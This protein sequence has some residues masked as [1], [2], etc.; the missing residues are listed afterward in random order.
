MSENMRSRN[1]A[2]NSYVGMLV[3]ALVGGL[4]T[5]FIVHVAYETPF[6]AFASP[7]AY[8]INVSL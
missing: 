8:E 3:V 2:I 1:I 4:A 7:S 5:L 6:S